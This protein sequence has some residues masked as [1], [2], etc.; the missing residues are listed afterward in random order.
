MAKAQINLDAVGG[1]SNVKTGTF[2]ITSQAVSQQIT[3]DTGLGASIKKF[4]VIG[5]SSTSPVPD[6]GYAAALAW[7]AK[8]PTYY[9]CGAYGANGYYTTISGTRYAAMALGITSYDGAGKFVLNTTPNANSNYSLGEYT[10]Y[11]E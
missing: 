11:A 9:E 2:S 6:G 3:I 8:T 4:V 5:I 7:S 10:W 1:T